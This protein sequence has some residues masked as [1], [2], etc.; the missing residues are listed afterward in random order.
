MENNTEYIQKTTQ[1]VLFE[2]DG[3]I[4]MMKDTKDH[5][6]LPGGRIDF[7]EDAD[8]AL[9]RELKEEMGLNPQ[10]YSIGNIIGNFKIVREFP[11]KHY[12]FIVL[13][14]EGKLNVE[15]FV[16]SDEHTECGWFTIPEILKLDMLSG[17]KE[18]FE[19]LSQ[20]K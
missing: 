8:T 17:Y 20:T 11:D 5:W 10:Q 19:K 7:A 12:H 4:L 3:K 18:F 6:E 13:V 16:I 14:Y 9:M 15:N 1:K 2:R